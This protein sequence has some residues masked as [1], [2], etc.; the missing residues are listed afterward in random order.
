MHTQDPVDDIMNEVTADFRRAIGVAHAHA[1]I[2]DRLVLD[3]GIGFGKTQNQNLEL[4][5]RL[6]EIASAFSAYPLLVG[7]SRKSFIGKIAQA[8]TPADR[9]G[10]SL[11][12]AIIATQN[13][14]Q[15]LRVHDVG[16][17]VH[18]LLVM[19]AIRDQELPN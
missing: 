6:R 8:S 2:D 19:S 16:A 18:A 4:L 9:L 14:A 3:V 13:G 5:A 12:T 1:V 17:T 7:T 11:A 10:G 15:I